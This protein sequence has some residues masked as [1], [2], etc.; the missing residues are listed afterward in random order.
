M[1]ESKCWLLDHGGGGSRNSLDHTGGGSTSGRQGRGR[2]LRFSSVGRRSQ[3]FPITTGFKDRSISLP[4][5]PW[6]G[7]ILYTRD[8]RWVRSR[9]RRWSSRFRPL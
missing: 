8:G 1:L 5:V 6:F 9:N 4:P 2:R 3:R 7:I